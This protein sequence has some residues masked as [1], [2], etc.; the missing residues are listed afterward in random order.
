M[1][2]A[3]LSATIGSLVD[4][5]VYGSGCAAAKYIFDFLR[6]RSTAVGDF[7]VCPCAQPTLPYVSHSPSSRFPTPSSAC[8]SLYCR[9]VTSLSAPS[10]CE[11]LR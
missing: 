4:F 6:P 2:V 9:P 7:I 1:A 3:V 8:C 5:L 10:S 11:D